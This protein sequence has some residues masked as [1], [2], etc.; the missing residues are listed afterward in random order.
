[1]GKFYKLVIKYCGKKFIFK[2]QMR[3]AE[4]ELYEVAKKIRFSLIGTLIKNVIN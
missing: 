2:K 4:K 1:V 3:D